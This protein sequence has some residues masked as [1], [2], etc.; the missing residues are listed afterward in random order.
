[1]QREPA[2]TMATILAWVGATSLARGRPYVG[3]LLDQRHTGTEL[4]A[5]SVGSAAQP[6]RV[7]ATL[8]ASGGIAASTYSCPVRAPKRAY[9][10][11]FPQTS[12]MPMIVYSAG[13]IS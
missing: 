7:T 6:Y 2:P 12:S 3:R 11:R 13:Q 4:K 1:M 5:R 9:G 8:T 10:A